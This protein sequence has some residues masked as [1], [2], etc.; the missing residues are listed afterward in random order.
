MSV[1]KN[2]DK[3]R[4]KGVMLA[5]VWLLNTRAQGLQ[6]QMETDFVAPTAISL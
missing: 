1:I 5:F 4:Y 3:R 6:A 2:G